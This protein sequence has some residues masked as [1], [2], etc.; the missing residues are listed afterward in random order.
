M[1]IPKDFEA[2]Y[3]RVTEAKSAAKKPTASKD[4]YA[5]SEAELTALAEAVDDEYCCNTYATYSEREHEIQLEVMAG[6]SIRKGIKKAFA[7]VGLKNFDLGKMYMMPWG[8]SH[9]YCVPR[10]TLAELKAGPKQSVGKKATKPATA[11]EIAKDAVFDADRWL[12]LQPEE[13][14]GMSRAEKR[15]MIAA[16]VDEDIED[17]FRSSPMRST[18][19]RSRL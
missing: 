19:P 14:E 1:S 5:P 17:Y 10:Y 4:P 13:L 7:K 9:L 11:L 8:D 18:R 6:S 3:A 16:A 2:I 15:E 12:R